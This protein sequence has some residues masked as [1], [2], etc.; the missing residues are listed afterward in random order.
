MGRRA[1]ARSQWGLGATVSVLALVALAIPIGAGVSQARRARSLIAAG[2]ASRWR[3]VMTSEMRQARA[4]NLGADALVG[5]FARHEPEGLRYLAL[6]DR[7]GMVLAAA[8]TPSPGAV[9]D[10]HEESLRE[11]GERLR[12]CFRL[13]PP[14]LDAR[15]GAMGRPGPPGFGPPGFGP[16][17]FGPPGFGPPGFGRP[18]EGGDPTTLGPPGMPRPD[19]LS[20]SPGVQGPL[21]FL[22]PPPPEPPRVGVEF[23]P[24]RAD[25][26]AS[27]QR[28]QELASGASLLAAFGALVFALRLLRERASLTEQVAQA[29][30]LSALGEM[31]AVLAHEIRNPLASL[32]GHA[33]LLEESVAEQPKL[34]PRAARVVREAVRLETLVHQL[35]VFARSGTI[36]RR[37][38]DPV[39]LVRA[40]LASIE[41]TAVDVVTE[42]APAVFSLDPEQLARCLEN[43]V[44]NALEAQG[45]G[46]R[47]TVTVTTAR[48]ALVFRVRDRGPGIPPGQER[49]IFEPFLTRKVRG[50]GLGLAIAKR[51]AELHGGTVRAYNHPDGGAEFCVEIPVG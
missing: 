51:A 39:A 23:V 46:A 49:E 20:V 41:T 7:E 29:R 4:Q 50:T 11:A 36:H 44:R 6:F 40:V 10:A 17:G 18:S 1:S 43:L 38:E 28:V 13:P 24:R 21:G 35:L 16:P 32:K 12:L 34:A 9:C 45:E 31:S 25:E 2:E 5:V 37:D 27:V 3:E 8:G 42:G 48:G 15:S 14:D 33:Q 22:R 19:G 26:L 47:A 30:H